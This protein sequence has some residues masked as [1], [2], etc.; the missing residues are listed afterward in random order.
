MVKAEPR[1]PCEVGEVNGPLEIGVNKEL[2]TSQCGWRQSATKMR[3][4]ARCPRNSSHF[5]SLR[6]WRSCTLARPDHERA[7]H[8][9]IL[10]RI[11][12][13]SRPPSSRTGSQIRS[14]HRR[15][16]SVSSMRGST[17]RADAVHSRRAETADGGRHGAALY[18]QG[19]RQLVDRC[20]SAEQQHRHARQVA[21]LQREN[22]RREIIEGGRLVLKTHNLP[23]DYWTNSSRDG[24]RLRSARRATS[25][26]RRSMHSSFQMSSVVPRH[27][28]GLTARFS[29]TPQEG[30]KTTWLLP[31]GCWC[32]NWRGAECQE[33]YRRLC[34]GCS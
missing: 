1:A 32:T 34:C 17:S 23:A 29:K 11:D 16:C 10:R 6:I 4:R 8:R 7:H 25:G 13:S 27:P 2:H 24:A 3:L 20:R 19:R 26:R 9:Q 15:A 14:I 31:V 18:M 22:V 12:L 33:H 28:F 21:R 30:R 5:L